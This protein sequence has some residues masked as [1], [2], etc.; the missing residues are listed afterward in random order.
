M[1]AVTKSGLSRRL[2]ISRARVTQLITEGLPVR[3]DG[4]IDLDAALAWVREHASANSKILAAARSETGSAESDSSPNAV[5]DE[6]RSFDEFLEALLNGQ[7]VEKAE[8]ERIK[9]NA[10]GRH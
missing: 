3:E 2:N 8:A 7:F 9:E 6:V 10:L 1:I 4:K 5:R